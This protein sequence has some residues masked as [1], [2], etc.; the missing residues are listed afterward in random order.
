MGKGY[1]LVDFLTNSFGVNLMIIILCD[2]R[3]LSAKNLAF[4]SKPNV[5]IKF[6]QELGSCSL[7]KKCQCTFF[8]RKYFE[9]TTSVQ[10]TNSR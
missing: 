6:L 4:F 10:P 8:G 2:F 1:I 5:M 3:Q 9:I 7:R